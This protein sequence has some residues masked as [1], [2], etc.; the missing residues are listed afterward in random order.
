MDN[1]AYQSD[2]Q[3]P[4]GEDANR[5]EEQE[6]SKSG[7]VSNEIKETKHNETS[8]RASPS[9]SSA[10]VNTDQ[11]EPGKANGA[12]G[13]VRKI[14]ANSNG[15]VPTGHGAQDDPNALVLD[16]EQLQKSKSLNEFLEYQ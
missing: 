10:D 2:D 9:S 8:G 12:A 7:D 15:R 6:I 1:K 16:A 4:S 3:L 5:T 14:S 13:H 11:P